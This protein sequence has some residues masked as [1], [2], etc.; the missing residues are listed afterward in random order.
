MRKRSLNF[1]SA[2]DESTELNELAQRMANFYSNTPIYYD[3]IDFAV[4]AWCDPEELIHQHI[5]NECNETEVCEVGCGRAGI[6][7]TGCISPAMYHGCDFSSQ[8]ID[9]N[10]KEFPGADFRVINE[11][12]RLPFADASFPLVFALFVLEHVVRPQVFLCDLVRICKPA[13]RIAIV[14]PNFFAQGMISSQVR[15]RSGLSGSEKLKRGQIVGAL[16]TLILNQVLLPRLFRRTLKRAHIEP[17]YL[18]NASPACFSQEFYPDSDAVYV[19]HQGEIDTTLREFGTV[20]C[21]ESIGEELIN[22][23]RNRKVIYSLYRRLA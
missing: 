3:D 23:C 4:S 20:P 10:R 12:N 6:L 17:V 15:G 2:R 21:G 14:C 8:L 16:Q 9:S 13:G 7:R 11:I 22:Y 19:T 1:I 5:L 18:I